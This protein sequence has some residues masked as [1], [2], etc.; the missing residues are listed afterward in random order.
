[1]DVGWNFRREH[2]RLQQ[3]SHY[4]ITERRRSAERRAAER[5]ASGT[6]SARPTT[7]H[8]KEL[9]DI[10]DKMAQGRRDDDR[11]RRHRRACSARRGRR[12]STR[13]SPRRCTRTS[14]RSGCRTWSEADQTL[15]KALQH[16]LKVPEIGLADE[17]RAAARPR[18]DSRRGE[19]RRRLGRHRRHLVER[20][21]GHAA[22]PVEH[23]RP[24]RATTGRTR[25]RWRR[26]S[27]TRASTA[28]AKVQAMTMLD[29]LMRPEL[30]D[31]GVGLLPERAD[32]GRRST[33]RSSGP[34]TSRPSG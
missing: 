7:P 25:S 34:R 17:D 30:V 3:R 1:M 23:P 29:L 5:D 21:D 11:H 10:G 28:G 15:A 9:W 24:A 31:A 13:P 8:I 32:E 4:V 20:A 27:R 33:S 22:L 6:T 18:V 14:R 2:L 26:R 16:E 12:T 19:A